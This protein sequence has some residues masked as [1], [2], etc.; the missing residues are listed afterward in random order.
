VIRYRIHT[1]ELRRSEPVFSTL[2]T[3]MWSK[4]DDDLCINENERNVRK[5]LTWLNDSGKSYHIEIETIEPE[6][7]TGIP[8]GELI[9]VM[10]SGFRG[11]SFETLLR[12]ILHVDKETAV[13]MKLFHPTFEQLPE[14]MKTVSPKIEEE[15]QNAQ[16]PNIPVGTIVLDPATNNVGVMVQNGMLAE[17]KPVDIAPKKKW[18]NF[19]RLPSDSI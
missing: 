17:L 14:P 4:T 7:I 13:L 9:V 11:K 15:I 1:E 18:W 6:G 12:Y 16:A 5:L 19:R 2:S 10:A 8:R 3:I